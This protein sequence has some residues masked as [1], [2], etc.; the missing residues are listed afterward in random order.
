MVGLTAEQIIERIANANGAEPEVMRR[1]IEQALQ[2]IIA[3]TT[4]PHCY[5]LADLFPG[6]KPTTEE[7]VVALEYDLYNAMMPTFPGWEWDGDGYRNT[8]STGK[9][10]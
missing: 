9:H 7:L 1:K 10:K 3:D 4:Q 8:K 6:G 2:N 5:M